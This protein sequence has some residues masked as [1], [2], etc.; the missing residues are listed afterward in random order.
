MS[1]KKRILQTYYRKSGKEK[2][3]KKSKNREKVAYNLL[4]NHRAVS[5]YFG[6]FL[7]PFSNIRSVFK[8]NFNT[9]AYAITHSI[10]YFFNSIISF[11]GRGQWHSIFILY[12]NHYFILLLNNVTKNNDCKIFHCIFYILLKQSPIVGH[13]TYSSLF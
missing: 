9:S 7:Q 4:A 1:F 8:L 2:K 5:L 3:R 12:Y 6:S 11:R 10:F 13:F